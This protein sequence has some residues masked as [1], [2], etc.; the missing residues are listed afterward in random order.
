MRCSFSLLQTEVILRFAIADKDSIGD[1]N[2]LDY[3][4]MALPEQLNQFEHPGDG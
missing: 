1:G 2:L 4:G 3:L